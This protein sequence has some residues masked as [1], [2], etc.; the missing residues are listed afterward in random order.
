[1]K[2]GHLLFASHRRALPGQTM[3]EYILVMCAMAMVSAGLFRQLG[4]HTE[5]V[6]QQA[7]NAVAAARSHGP[8]AQSGGGV[9]VNLEESSMD[10]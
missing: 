5:S 3:I 7:S 4:H 2:Q 10:P 9:N 8:S 1:M 6:V